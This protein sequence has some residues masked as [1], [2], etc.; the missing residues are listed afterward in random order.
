[1][2]GH[3]FTRKMILSNLLFLLWNG[4]L[5]SQTTPS[6]ETISIEQGLSQGFIAGMAQDEDGFLW[7]ATSNGLNRYDGYEFSVFRNNP[8]DTLSIGGNGIFS[9]AATGEFLWLMPN[10]RQFNIFHRATQRAFPFRWI[11]RSYNV[12]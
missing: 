4:I 12:F 11:Y 5:H 7:F 2:I 1:M 9:M 3:T 6:L 10:A 8:Y